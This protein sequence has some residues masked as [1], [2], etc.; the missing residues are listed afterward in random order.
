M[1]DRTAQ[2]EYEIF[3]DDEIIP[4]NGPPYVKTV[5]GKSE[6]EAEKSRLNESLT[7]EQ[8]LQGVRA[9]YR[10]SRYPKS[11]ATGRR[12]STRKYSETKAGKR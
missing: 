11:K 9:Y 10:P 4:G 8:K 7:A 12:R 2:V 6:A 1:A 3:L 5:Q